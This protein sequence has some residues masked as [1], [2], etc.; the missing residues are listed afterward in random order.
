MCI[1]CIT[2]KFRKNGSNIRGAP[3]DDMLIEKD[4]TKR[5]QN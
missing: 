1:K 3:V 4:D 2:Q 5:Y